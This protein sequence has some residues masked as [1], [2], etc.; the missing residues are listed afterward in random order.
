MQQH[1]G[2]RTELEHESLGPL[3]G[4]G[5]QPPKNS[6]IPNHKNHLILVPQSTDSTSHQANC[7]EKLRIGQLRPQLN[8]FV[9]P[10]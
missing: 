2:L 4:N 9:Q 3:Y 5:I 10:G 7:D 6:F 8:N 1:D